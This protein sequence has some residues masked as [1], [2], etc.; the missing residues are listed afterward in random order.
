MLSKKLYALLLGL[1]P[2]VYALHNLD[3]WFVFNSSI[4]TFLKVSPKFV[5]EIV[6]ENP[7]SIS[8]IFGFALI[9]ATIIPLLVAVILW[10][11]FSSFSIKLLLVV[12]FATL[13]NAFS[14]I[15]S[16]IVFGFIAPGLITGVLLCIPYSIIV[17]Y[18][19][20]KY[21]RLTLRLYLTLGVVSIAVY[22]LVLGLSWSIGQLIF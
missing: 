5:S 20:R 18:Y 2:L 3:E 4:D 11:R 10:N 12:A 14:H 22:A 7:M 6:A 19:I 8:S 9:V 13:I 17:I 15:L 16:S 1:F 21:N